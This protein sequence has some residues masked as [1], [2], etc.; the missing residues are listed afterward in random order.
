MAVEAKRLRIAEARWPRDRAL[1]EGL[2]RD[3]VAS[4]DADISFQDVLSELAGLP[5]K[6]ARPSGV[7]LIAW[8]GEEAAGAVAYRPLEP[9]VCEMKRLYVKPEFR[10]HG[11]ARTLAERLIEEA[12]TI[13]YRTMVLD[14]LAS[15]QAA[16]AL[17]RTLGFAPI[18]AY[19][20]NPLPGA[21]YLRLELQAT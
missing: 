7:A 14:T 10:G 3:Y 8:L 12:R 17:Y 9:G 13:G 19:Y 16:L 18:P 11:I 4:L 2:F 5:G 21:T 1:V 15:M 20:D 6:Y